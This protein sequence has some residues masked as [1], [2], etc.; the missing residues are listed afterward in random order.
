MYSIN[1]KKHVCV[2]LFIYAF[3]VC[4]T[5][6]A[7][8]FNWQQSGMPI[9]EH[10]DTTDISKNPQ[11]FNIKQDKKGFIYIGNGSGILVFDG[12]R[13]KTIS[14]GGLPF[15]NFDFSQDG[16]IYTGTVGDLGYFRADKTG[17]WIFTSLL[18]GLKDVP[19]ISGVYEVLVDGDYVYYSTSSHFF[20]Y[21]PELGMQW[22]E[23]ELFVFDFVIDN[24][25]LLITSSGEKRYY[26][27][28]ASQKLDQILDT[29][30]ESIL[31]KGFSKLND[32][33]LLAH[34]QNKLFY[35]NF[36]DNNS[37]SLIPKNTEAD[38][39]LLDK[40]ISDLVQMGN[41]KLAISTE[42]NGIVI[43][44]QYGGLDRFY[45]ANHGLKNN[46]VTSLYVDREQSLWVSSLSD[47]VSRVEIN[48]PISYFSTAEKFS[49]SITTA[50]FNE[51]VIFGAIDG[52]FKL[53]P[54][55]SPDELAKLNKLNVNIKGAMSFLPDDEELLV[56]HFDGISF[57]SFDAENNCHLTT[58]HDAVLDKGYD[59]R[60]IIRS[61]ISPDFAYAVS[62]DGLIQL[63][64]K[65][66]KWISKGL[67]SEI[68]DSLYSTL[69]DSKGNLWLGTQTGTYY[70]LEQLDKW[71]TVKISELNYPKS[72]PPTVASLFSLDEHILF[73]NGVDNELKVFSFETKQLIKSPMAYWDEQGLHGLE[74]LYQDKKGLGWFVTKSSQIGTLTRDQTEKYNVDFSSLDHLQLEFILG[75]THTKDNIL[76]INSKDTITR[77]DTSKKVIEAKLRSPVLTMIEQIGTGRIL[78]SNNNFDKKTTNLIFQPEENTIRMHYTSAEFSHRK[79]TEYRYRRVNSNDWSDWQKNTNIELTNLD[80][81]IHQLEIQYRTNPK[82][83]SPILA[84]NLER[85]P[86]WYQTW[87]GF[88]SIAL[89]LIFLTLAFNI[90]FISM[91]H[92]KIV[93]RSRELRKEVQERTRDIQNH[94]DEIR[95]INEAKERLF[96]NFSHEFRTPLSLSIGPLKE[97]LRSGNTGDEM[98]ERHLKMVLRNNLHMMDLLGQILDIKKLSAD[99]MP[100][101]ILKI[102][103]SDNLKYCIQRFQSFAEQ[104]NIGFKEIGLEQDFFLY[105]DPDHFEKIILN[106][107]SNAVKYSPAQSVIEVGMETCDQRV[108]IWVKDQGIG[109]SKED[110]KYIFDRYYQGEKPPNRTQAGTGI[111]LA[112][113]KELVDLHQAKVEVVSH[114]GEGA[115][116]IVNFQVKNK[117]YDSNLYSQYEKEPGPRCD[118]QPLCFELE[119]IKTDIKEEMKTVLV[120]DDNDEL[121]QFIRTILQSQYNVLEA[122]NGQ[123]GLQKAQDEQP[124][125]IVS[126]IMMPILDGLQLAKKLKAS[127]KTDYIPLILLTARATKTSIVEGLQSGADDYLSKP[128]FSEE[129]NA[130]IAAQI[131][132]KKRYANQLLKQFKLKN[133]TPSSS[134]TIEKN[135]LSPSEERFSKDL[136]SVLQK[137]LSDPDFDVEKMY[138]ELNVTRSTLFRNVKKLFECT[139]KYLLKTRRLECALYILKTQNGRV[140]EVAYA[141]GFH[142]LSN[143][144]RAFSSHFGLPPT[145]FN[146]IPNP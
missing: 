106:L 98:N 31:I 30:E 50:P 47:G 37:Y 35:R 16:N 104:S 137:N 111:G 126:D 90:A 82:V 44:D 86:F 80:P 128:F 68:T 103:A 57:L 28:P 60:Q 72:R 96:G 139:P 25:K 84:I 145:R 87:W 99:K 76:W 22:F 117:Y 73:N 78:Y 1:Y 88:L 113:V 131:A 33:S 81:G 142:S 52:L 3:F 12:V 107:L 120:I 75:I 24:H 63:Q 64:K 136:N 95:K 7:S 46:N 61:K 66:G 49:L 89:T 115:C 71:P 41:G 132:Q 59:V 122:E 110:K 102:K 56:G 100:V 94:Y 105:I 130:R 5:L 13:W 19:S 83:V 141:V 140:S 14:Y 133:E 77:Y 2:S 21:H 67:L 135:K 129:L 134:A 124:D 15:R 51:S 92:K 143:F 45:N 58:V 48:S 79:T 9:S 11:N 70:Y 116:F 74:F 123:E 39:W 114:A 26:F 69:E 34:S 20:F 91:R 43:I 138:Q 4:L 32:G 6:D 8:H 112:L 118:E 54:A 127:T 29:I 36:S 18:D 121:R 55:S 62:R 97:V 144:S 85:L 125:V 27:D 23:N 119:D 108:K 38:S 40:R 146:D 53:I 109:I 17:N 10:F 101:N 93:E 65:N 42:K